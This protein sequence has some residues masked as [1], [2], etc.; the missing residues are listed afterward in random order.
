VAAIAHTPRTFAFRYRSPEHW[1]DVFRRFYGPTHTAFLALDA[2][3]Q[4]SLEAALLALLRSHDVG[5]GRGLVVPG[6]YLETVI[7]T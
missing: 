5:G 3:G 4:A 2:E 6:Q 7:T 1:V